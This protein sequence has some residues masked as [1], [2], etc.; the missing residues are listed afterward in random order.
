[1]SSRIAVIIPPITIK[2]LILRE[3]FVVAQQT[4]GVNKQ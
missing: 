3:V 1:M 2:P 4:Y